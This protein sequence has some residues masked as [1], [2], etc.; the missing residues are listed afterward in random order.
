MTDGKA[1]ITDTIL[2]TLDSP[3]SK[4]CNLL[5]LGSGGAAVRSRKQQGGAELLQGLNRRT[6]G[7]RAQPS[8]SLSSTEGQKTRLECSAEKWNPQPEVTWR[9]MN[10]A[11][12]TSQ[13][14][15]TSELDSEGLLRVSSVLPVK[16]EYNVFSCLMRSKAPKPDWHSGLGIYSE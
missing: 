2:E 6:D 1:D 10:G 7:Q 5:G 8:I 12:V 13:S 16:E 11:D 9:D 4:T 3:R 14:T 15:I